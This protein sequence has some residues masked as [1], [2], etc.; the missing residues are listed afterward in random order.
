MFPH[1]VMTT[2]RDPGRLHRSLAEYV[3]THATSQPDAPALVTTARPAC[4]YRE[5][6]A[7][8]DR[9]GARLAE[10][11]PAGN[12]VIAVAASS[13]PDLFSAIVAAMTGGICAPFDPSRPRPKSTRFL[14][15]SSRRSCS[16]MMPRS[17]AIGTLFTATVSGSFG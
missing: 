9:L 14:P 12:S 5:L 15:K 17:C 7:H 1:F 16:R 8:L 13:G 6:G 11:S 2:I 3:R 10:W 4:T